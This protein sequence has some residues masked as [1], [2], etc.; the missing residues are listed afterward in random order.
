MRLFSKYT[1]SRTDNEGAAR[2]NV[3]KKEYLFLLLAALA[4][5]IFQLFFYKPATNLPLVTPRIIYSGEN[6]IKQQFPVN[7]QLNGKKS[8]TSAYEAKYPDSSV[9][10]AT[11]VFVSSIEPEA[12]FAN[13]VKWAKDNGWNVINSV[14]EGPVLS[15][16]LRRN[17]ED[18]NIVIHGDSVKISDIK[19]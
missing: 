2:F 17:N 7:L 15:I 18:L 19:R 16:Y 9:R 10:Q 12:N 5:V 13:Y 8:F 1:F 4:V 3:L 6:A 14:S 11:A